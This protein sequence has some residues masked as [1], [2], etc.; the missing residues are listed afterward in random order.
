MVRTSRAVWWGALT[1]LLVGIVAFGSGMAVALYWGNTLPMAAWIGPASAAQLTTPGD[2]RQDFKVYW[3]TWNLVE[4]NFYRRAPLQHQQ[5]VY[6]SIQGMLKS[7]GDDYT[8][9]QPPDVAEQSRVWMSGE[10]EGIGAYIEWKNGQLAIIAPIEGSPAEQAGLK[11]GDIVLKVDDAELSPQ[12]AKLD[13]NAATEKARGMIRGPKGT[14]VKLTILRPGTKEQL[15][16]TIKRAALPE[17]SVRGKMLDNGVAYIQLTTFTGTTT[18]QLDKALKAL[19]PK[20]PRS[21]ILDLRNNP[22]G[23]VTSAQEVIGRFVNG[24]TALYEQFGNGTT[25]EKAVLRSTTDPKAFDVPMVVLINGGSASAAEIVAGA[26]RDRQRATMIG[27]KSF[28]KGSV[29]SIEQLSDNSSARITIAHWLTPAHA[30][31]HKIGIMPK[32][33]VPMATDEKY[34]VSLP[35]VLPVDPT[36]TNDSQLWWAIKVLTTKETPPPPPPT[37]TPA[38]K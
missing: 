21:I 10:W 31:I 15:V 5:M 6:A 30:E 7:L 17:I 38:P 8:V 20:H 25:E 35:Q 16:L 13:A 1:A 26:L 36:S 29:Q 4:K 9:F 22:G 37:P 18:S 2:I 11:P 34:H 19:L 27:E 3:E 33:V 23:L 14:N 24:G 12:L 32:Y 28:G